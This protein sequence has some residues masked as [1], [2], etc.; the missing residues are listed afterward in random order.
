MN[1]Q[2]KDWRSLLLPLREDI[3]RS[4][5]AS[6][7]PAHMLDTFRRVRAS[8]QRRRTALRWLIAATAAAACLALYVTAHR[9]LPPPPPRLAHLAIPPAAPTPPAS[10][11][12]PNTRRSARASRLTFYALR[13]PAAAAPIEHGQVFRL[14]VPGLS[15]AEAGVPVSPDR[16]FENVQADVLFAEDGSARAARLVPQPAAWHR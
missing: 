16:W 5:E 13:G 12:A 10:P 1:D 6:D 11:T 4:A 9:P 15:L 8:Q 2:D 3:A 7:S 14:V